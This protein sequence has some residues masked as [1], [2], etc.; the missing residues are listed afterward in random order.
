MENEWILAIEELED[1]NKELKKYKQ[2]WEAL[3]RHTSDGSD[4]YWSKDGLI[5]FEEIWFPK[6]EVN[7]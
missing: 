7:G 1:E 3:K 2:M 6:E 5:K 4:A